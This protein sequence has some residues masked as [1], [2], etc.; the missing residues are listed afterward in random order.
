MT[1]YA[2]RVN[3]STIQIATSNLREIVFAGVTKNSINT[4]PGQ[5]IRQQTITSGIISYSDF[6]LGPGIACAVGTTITG[7]LCRAIDPACVSAPNWVGDCDIFGTVSINPRRVNNFN[8]QDFGAVGD[9]LTDCSPSIQAAIDAARVAGGTVYIPSGTFM[10]Y[11]ELSI[12][13]TGG[14]LAIQGETNSNGG[15][16]DANRS[17]LKAAASIRSCLSLGRYGSSISGVTLDANGLATHA[18]Y[19]QGA[20]QSTFSNSLCTNAL[21]DGIHLAAKTDANTDVNNDNITYSH[22]AL[23]RNGTAWV[24]ASIAS[25]YAALALRSVQTVAGTAATTF[26]GYA[27]T[28]TGAPDLTTLGLRPGDILRLGGS[29]SAVYYQIGAVHD[30]VTLYLSGSAYIWPTANASGLPFAILRG[31]GYFEEH[32]TD[33]Q[34]M[35]WRAGYAQSNAACGLHVCNF[36]GP[37][38][39]ASP[40]L[41]FNGGFGLSIGLNTSAF[42]GFAAYVLSTVLIKPYFEGNLG[43]NILAVTADGCDVLQPTLVLNEMRVDISTSQG[44]LSLSSGFWP[45]GVD[46]G[47]SSRL[48]ATQSVGLRNVG[49]LS[50]VPGSQSVTANNTTLQGGFSVLFVGLD[51]PRTLTSTPSI[52]AGQDGQEMWLYNNSA[53]ALTLQRHDVLPGSGLMLAATTLVIPAYGGVSLRYSASLIGWIQTSLSL[54][55]V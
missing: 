53:N 15:G 39:S 25:E 37:E 44:Y 35:V 33:S 47:Y 4:C 42:G 55:V 21:A 26:G 28:F 1:Y 38:V 36:Y 40:L 7:A 2:A 16:G 43:G 49:A 18:L 11:S 32:A 22:V 10:L 8:L 3:G 9:G 5:L 17:I 13:I 6:N 31:S 29:G 27:V 12:P 34:L 51:T 41:Q 23:L 19:I 46:G 14:A 50:C 48:Y 54:T 20:A 52:A 24:S 45:F 30:A